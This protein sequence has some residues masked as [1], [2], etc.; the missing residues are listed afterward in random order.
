MDKENI[1]SCRFSQRRKSNSGIILFVVLWAVVILTTL[2][3]SLGRGTNIELA[4]TK[5]SIGKLKAKYL[6]WAGLIYA[7]NQI[8]MDSE[9]AASNKQDTLYYCGIPMDAENP[10]ESLFK[11]KPMQDGFYNVAFVE[12]TLPDAEKEPAINFNAYKLARESILSSVTIVK[13]SFTRPGLEDEERKINLNALNI[14]NAGILSSLIVLLG[15]DEE[16]ARTAAFSVV[17]WQ[18]EGS[19]LSHEVYGAEDDY[20]MPQGYHCKDIYFDSLEELL[21][22]RGVTDELFEK[23]KP[24]VTIYPKGGGLKI[25][26]DTAP[27]VVLKAMA[28]NF[29]GESSNTQTSDAESLVEKILEYRRGG[30]GVE[31]T[32]DDQPLD[33]TN[34]PLNAKERAIFLAMSPFKTNRAQYLRV[35]V[36]A[37]EKK[38]DVE[39]RIEAVVSR[40]DLAIV[41]WR[42][43]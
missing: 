18:D 27:E 24:F 15:F 2:A 21:L 12:K 30:D 31:F 13:T 37:V 14:S 36:K 6:A 7:I 16:T 41:E 33:G 26:F 8:R 28:L 19:T 1:N 40:E 35:V 22:V 10:P 4:L 43:Q 9:D 39:T 23:L 29:A 17:D 42:I 20:Y 3:V 5:Y 32:Q 34:L 38:L 11:E 25:N